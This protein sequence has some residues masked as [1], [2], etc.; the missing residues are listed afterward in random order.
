MRLTTIPWLRISLVGLAL[1]TLIESA[2]AADEVPGNKALL[3][4]KVPATATLTVHDQPTKSTGPERS[5]I[6]PVLE[7]GK[8]YSYILV[9]TWDEGGEKKSVERKVFVF[10]GQHTRE[11]LT[12]EPPEV[13]E[14]KPKEKDPEPKEQAKSRT[15]LFTYGGAVTG[16]KAGQ[17]AKMWLPVPPTNEDQTVTVENDKGLPEGAKL[18]EEK[19]YGNKMY[20]VETKADKDGKIPFSVTYKVTRKEV[21][22]ATGQEEPP[23]EQLKRFLEPDKLVP[24]KGKAL[25]LI[26]GKTVP[27]D[28]TRASAKVFYD[29]VNDHM[30]YGKPEGK[31]WG[32]GDTEWACDSKVGNCTDFHSIFIS[33][34]RANKV[35]AKFEMGFSVP[36]KRGS[37]D[38][39]GYH[40]WAKYYLKGKGWV[41][42]D[43]SEA[44]KNPKMKDY[45]FGNLTEDRVVMTTGRDIILE[46]RQDG[47]AL[48]Y[49]IFPY[50][51]VG[52]KPLDLKQIQRKITFQDLPADK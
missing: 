29:V 23:A 40:C 10:A 21:K 14:K 51:E 1:A 30:K 35:P 22:G 26:K 48:N 3:T 46:P 8:K 9:A 44:N 39:A 13:I 45:Y 18:G 33:L 24:V 19:E 7:P 42:V 15:F 28:D 32:R 31:P 12:R 49:F 41:P 2:P 16:L 11:D 4:V 5:F 17:D 6:T 37:G 47:E 27:E 38:I 50:V 20:Y 36:E 25:E 43:I 34:A 52:E